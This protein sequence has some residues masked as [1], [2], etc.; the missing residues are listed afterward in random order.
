MSGSDTVENRLCENTFFFSPAPGI[1]SNLFQRPVFS[2]LLPR[3]LFLPHNL[4]SLLEPLE[5]FAALDDRLHFEE[6]RAGN[7]IFDVPF[8][9]L[10]QLISVPEPARVEH[11]Q[12]LA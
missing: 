5:A 4:E 7:E 6:N 8:I 1:Y 2:R 10:V 3:R 11:L 12:P 9:I